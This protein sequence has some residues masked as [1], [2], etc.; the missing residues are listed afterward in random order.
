MMRA[1]LIAIV[2]ASVGGAVCAQPANEGAKELETCFQSARA[3]DAICSDSKNGAAERLD[4]GQKALISQIECL[5]HISPEESA[6]SVRPEMPAGTVSP[7]MPTV[8]GSPEVPAGSVS[9]ETPTGT[10]SPGEPVS[11]PK[12]LLEQFHR[13]RPLL[14]GRRSVLNQCMI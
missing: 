4:C 12:R 11:S 9:P 10:V 2:L 6:G 8:T 7:K 3:A 5:K 1:A 13:K 14:C